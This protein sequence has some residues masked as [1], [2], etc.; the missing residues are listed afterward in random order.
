[1]NKN[2]EQ[3]T[4]LSYVW[5]PLD[6]GPMR[7]KNRIVVPARTLNWSDDGI[8]SDR[9]LDH[10]RNLVEGGASLII[11]EQHA[12]YPVAKGSF[13]RPCSAW[14]T[15][16]IPRFERVAEIVHEHDARGVV[17]LYGSGANDKGTLLMD[18]WKALWGVSEVP[19]VVHGEVP[20]IMGKKEFGE[21][22]QGFARS[23]VNVRT[24]GM[25]GVELHAAHG[26]LLGQFLSR[27][28]NNRTDAYGG[29][30]ENRCRIIVEIASAIREKVGHDLAVGIRLS[31]DEFVEGV[32]I[33]PEEADEQVNLLLATGLFDYFSISGGTYHTLHKAVGPMEEP[34]GYLVPFADRAKKLIGDRAAVMTVGKIRDLHRAE[35]IL[36]AGSADAVAMGRAQ[37]ADPHIVRKTF[38]G[39]ENE[40]TRCTG[41]N[42]CIARL[43]EDTEVICAMNPVTGRE[44][45]WRQLLPVSIPLRK[46][47]LVIGGGPSGMKLASVAATRGHSVTL[48][49]E[50]ETL[51]GHLRLLGA[52]PNQPGWNVAIDNLERGLKNSGVEVIMG[53]KADADFVRT[54]AADRTFI[55]TGARWD[56]RGMSVWSPALNEVPGTTEP[57]VLTI[58][59]AARKVLKDGPLALGK[60]VVIVDES[61]IVLPLGVAQMVADAGAKVTVISP[62]MYIGKSVEHQLEMP[63][64]FPPLKAAG[65][66]VINQHRF[67]EFNGSSAFFEDIWGTPRLVIDDVSTLVLSVNRRPYYPLF[68]EVANDLGDG[69]TLLGDCKSPRK[70]S[71]LTYEAE[72][73][74]RSI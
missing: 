3:A 56:T 18:E 17:Q 27:I 60:K 41:Q 35:D 58:D 43:F 8:L 30:V 44:N 26:Y 52:I 6:I 34:D 67:V 38:E 22:V 54:F 29:S 25:D 23:A 42:E 9:H 20:H 11:T 55:A 2:P 49:D 71:A 4:D 47:V 73:L 61:G 1:M 32:G 65:V 46:N 51:G 66:D 63:Y 72:L 57:N 37:L 64:V 10:Y 24:G 62:Q 16:S 39:R 69:V 13:H 70:L 21:I 33:T 74:A 31:Y 28:Y 14:D 19:S 45:R 48:V 15:R 12:A 36:R 68:E 59:V 7:L 40:I 53:Q 5:Q 50:N